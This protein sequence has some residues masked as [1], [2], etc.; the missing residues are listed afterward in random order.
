MKKKG[1]RIFLCL[2]RRNFRFK[3]STGKRKF[4]KNSSFKTWIFFL[5][6]KVFTSCSFSL[7]T[8]VS[9]LHLSAPISNTDGFT[10]KYFPLP[11]PEIIKKLSFI[12]DFLFSE[13]IHFINSERRDIMKA[14]IN[15]WIRKV[16]MNPVM[17]K[18][19]KNRKRK[20]KS[21]NQNKIFPKNFFK[22]LFT[23]TFSE[24]H[25]CSCIIFRQR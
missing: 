18:K 13:F 24:I 20:E 14:E 9:L 1:Q 10:S 21:I 25:K 3:K 4:S 19:G 23:S 5:L 17:N 6:K 16:W 22:P 11:H 2:K 8:S 12:P 7:A 15:E